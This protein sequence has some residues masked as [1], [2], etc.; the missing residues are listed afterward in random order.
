[1][2][3]SQRA[4]HRDTGVLCAPDD[5][6]QLFL[7]LITFVLFLLR[8]AKMSAA[9][10]NVYSIIVCSISLLQFTSTVHILW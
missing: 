3:V 9:S 5:G 8:R 1:M 6:M 7:L 10:R 4:Q 2:T